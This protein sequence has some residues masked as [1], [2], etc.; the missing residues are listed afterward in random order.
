MTKITAIR[1]PEELKHKA[2]E[3]GKQEGFSTLT[4]LVIY[5]LTQFVKKH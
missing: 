4:S 2:L 3:K 5:L 1:I